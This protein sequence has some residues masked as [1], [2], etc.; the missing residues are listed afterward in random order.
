M[1]SWFVMKVASVFTVD[2]ANY[3]LQI[4]YAIGL[5]IITVSLD[6]VTAFSIALDS[7]NHRGMSYLD[8]RARFTMND[9][10]FNFHSLS[11]PL[12]EC[13]IGEIRFKMLVKFLDAHYP[14]WR[15]ILIGCSTD[16]VRS[17]TSSIHVLATRL[18]EC[19]SAMLI[20]IWCGIH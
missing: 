6:K 19:T 10:I 17:I 4:I 13:H 12:F 15:N 1:V 9:C 11:K 3:L 5:H 20:R 18:G 16:G 8:V 2:A 14:S 7:T